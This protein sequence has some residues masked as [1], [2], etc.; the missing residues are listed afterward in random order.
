MKLFTFD[1]KFMEYGNLGAGSGVFQ[2]A[3]DRRA[4]VQQ[5]PALGDRGRPKKPK[6]ASGNLTHEIQSGN[7][8][9]Q[10]ILRI[11]LLLAMGTA[12]CLGAPTVTQ[13]IDPPEVNVGEEVTVTIAVQNGG[14][15]NIRLPHVDGLEVTGNNIM[16][17]FTWENGVAS[18]TTQ[19]IF[20]LVPSRLGD[21]IIPSFDVHT[22]DGQILH[23]QAMKLHVLGSAAAPNSAITPPVP[24]ATPAPSSNGPV[25]MP[26]NNP[27]APDNSESS[28]DTT[29][30]N[31]HVPIDPDGRPA[32]V[33]MMV[34]PT[35]TDA[36]VGESIPT[37]IEF[38]IRLDVMAGQ[39]SLP[40]I[41]GSDFLMNNLSVR[42]NVDEAMVNGEAY[43]RETWVTA[44]SAPKSGDFPFQMERDTYWTKQSQVNN[45]DPFGFFF[46]RPS[47]AHGN[48]GSNPLT[49]H[50]HPLPDEGRPANFSGAIGHFKVTD[51]AAPTTVSVGEPVTLHFAV[52]GDGNFDYVRCPSLTTD[53]NWKPYV[54]SSKI[55]YQ[56][57]THT[58][59]VKTF[60]QAVIPQKNGDLPLPAASFSYF[61]STAKQY[62]TLPIALPTV[63]VSGSVPVAG[64]TAP[65]DNN[66]A[67]TVPV[68]VPSTELVPNRV[69]IGSLHR[70]L[71]PLYR[72][73]WF[74]IVQTGL[75]LLLIGG[76]SLL[77]F[78]ARFAPDRARAERALR[79]SSL[80]RQE[81]TMSDA[82][83]RNDP[84]AFFLSARN[85]V[86]LQLGGRWRMKPEAITFAEIRERD[87]QLAETLEPL[88]KQADEI[89]YSG[90]TG[91]DLNLAEWEL[92]IR[93]DL[94]QPQPAHARS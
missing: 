26:P 27:A 15:T 93:K 24:S 8:Y 73:P 68:A 92:H 37:R 75:M 17:N 94:L 13:Q 52:S 49:F 39:D 42:P 76:A 14:V 6:Q 85:A 64:T 23:V 83:R 78:R 86:Q 4:T 9:S 72:Q 43:R 1:K 31:T 65:G 55:E 47:L 54:P 34:T 18:S 21:F 48:V 74:W 41:K 77:F 5:I 57:E 3:I 12:S 60:E 70:S 50:I 81:D 33:F 36:Y 38:Y 10:I 30:T 45:N 16:R 28:T 25:V 58:Q 82:V 29:A 61:D 63:N 66:P 40:T 91:G 90:Q 84:Q 56:E 87:P 35:T 11:G 88:F 62:V 2:V 53:P 89:I 67:A 46:S 79:E 44:V 51:S 22:Q 20:T 69:D 32:K 59:G 19:Q 80:H 7:A 71:T